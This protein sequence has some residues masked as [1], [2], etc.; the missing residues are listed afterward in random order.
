[1]LQYSQ[2]QQASSLTGSEECIESPIARRQYAV[3]ES[4]SINQHYASPIERSANSLACGASKRVKLEGNDSNTDILQGLTELS[5]SMSK[6]KEKTV[7][8]K[9]RS[10]REVE[11]E[12]Q[13]ISLAILILQ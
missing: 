9:V 13:N 3:S 8:T 4:S 11:F 2:F 1:M 12:F 10:L 6:V 5:S 7:S